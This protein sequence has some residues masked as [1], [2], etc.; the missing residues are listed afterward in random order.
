MQRFPEG[1]LPIGDAISHNNPVYGQGMSSAARQAQAPG[2]LVAPRAAAGKPLAGLR[3]DYFPAVYEE[4]R[5]PWLFA[6]LADFARPECTGDSPLDEQAAI[7]ILT[8]LGERGAGGDVEAA[9]LLADVGAL[10]RP[11]SALHEVH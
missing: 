6:A 7:E 4:I 5:A 9:A 1:L 11:L 8:D 2:L 3:Q 10:R